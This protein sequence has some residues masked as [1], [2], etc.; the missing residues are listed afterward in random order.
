MIAGCY[1]RK[2]T[3]QHVADD[4]KSVARQV[5]RAKEYAATKGWRFDDRYVFSDDAVSGA[6]FRKRP[7]LTKLLAA[8]QPKPKFNV[9]II[10]EPSRLGREQIETAYVLKQIIDE[11]V[12]VFDY[13]DDKEITIGSAMEKFVASVQHFSAES[14]RE[15]GSKRVRDKMRQ[16]A[17]QGKY[18]GGRLFGYE[19]TTGQR[20]VKPSEAAIVRR[21]FKRR[22]DGAG[23]FK[24]ARELEREGIASPRGG[25]VWSPTQVGL[26]LTNETYNGIITYSR[27]RQTKRRGTSVTLKS[28]EAIIRTEVPALRIIEPALWEKV[29]K[30]NVAAAAS[31]WRSKDGRLKSRPTESKHLLTPFLAC[32][33]CGGSMHVRV[34]NGKPYLNCTNHHHYGAARCPN[35]KRLAVSLAEKAIMTAFEEALAG[36]IIIERL[37]EA[38]ARQRAATQDPTPLREEAKTLR[39]EITRMVTALATGK[40]SAAVTDAIAERERR[41]KEIEETLAGVTAIADIDV[42]AFRASIVEVAADWRA[43]LRKNPSTGQQV[44][45]KILPHR[46]KVTPSSEPGVAW[47]FTGQTDYKKVLAEAGFEAALNALKSHGLVDGA[48][49]IPHEVNHPAGECRPQYACWPGTQVPRTGRPS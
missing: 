41:I 37:Q 7:G 14:E 40:E 19:T 11:G 38:L 10:S 31:T 45:R 24:I 25:K 3:E 18:T 47:E 16:L 8:L 46:L 29:Q 30:V 20:V 6:E 26:L 48:T 39:Q 28:P 49:T 9:L 23:Y 13:L 2:S 35:G 43:H 36:G 42:E 15:Q 34:D 22:A 5:Q 21:I 44:L 17:E 4:A 32:G 1:A 12:R 27:T 33:L